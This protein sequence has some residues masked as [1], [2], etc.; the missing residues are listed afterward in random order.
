MLSKKEYEALVHI[1]WPLMV[2]PLR[3]GEALVHIGWPLM[4]LLLKTLR[5]TQYDVKLGH[6]AYKILYVE[7]ALLIVLRPHTC[8]DNCIQSSEL[9]VN[10]C[11]YG[12]IVLPK[13]VDFYFDGI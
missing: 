10:L 2:L 7:Q 6:P 13:V 3:V 12:V 5:N 8:N 9:L 11:M 1:D 4:V